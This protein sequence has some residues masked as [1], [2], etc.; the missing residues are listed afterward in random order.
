MIKEIVMYAAVCDTCGKQYE[1]NH[2]GYCAWVDDITARDACIN[3]GV[4]W[5]E[6]ENK[7]YCPECTQQPMTL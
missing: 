5:L 7:L 2:S 6:N 4:G 1:D 3:S